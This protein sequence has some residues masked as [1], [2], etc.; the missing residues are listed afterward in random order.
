MV[1]GKILRPRF[2]L[3]A[4]MIIGLLLISACGSSATSTAQPTESINGTSPPNAVS[5]ARP[6]SAPTATAV[7]SA[8]QSVMMQAT[9]N[10]QGKYGG[11]IPVH[12][13]G[14]ISHW[15]MMEC[16]SGGTCMAPVSPFSN[17]LVQY[18]GETDDP[19]D[20]RGD[21]ATGWTLSEDGTSYVF[22]LPQ[23]ARWHDGVEITADDVVFSLEEMVRDDVPRSR[24]GQIGP[25]YKSSKALDPYTVQVDL[26]FATS[27]FLSILSLEFMKMWPKHWV[28]TDPATQKDMRLEEN[29]LGSGPFKMVEH[30]KDVSIKYEKN[31]DYFKEGLPYFDGMEYFM[32]NDSSRIVAAYKAQQVLMTSYLNSN[33]NVR[34]AQELAKSMEG[35]GEVFFAAPALWH[36]LLMNT[37]VEPFNNIKVRQAIQLVLHRQAFNE[38]FGA[39]QYQLGS[40]LPPDLWF[41]SST[42]DLLQ[43]PGLR[44]TADGEK[45]PRDIAEAQRLMAEAGYADGFKTTILGANFLGFPDMAQVA[46]DQMR[47]WLNIDAVVQPEEPAAGYV[48]YEAGDW[49]MGFHGSGIMVLDPDH[50]MAETYLATGARN[51]S[52]W[53]PSEITEMNDAQ[54]HE[55]DFDKRRD[56]VLQMEEYLLNVDSHLVITEWA[57]LIPYVDNRIKNYHVASGFA[58]HTM[59]EHLWYEP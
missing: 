55:P 36:A 39:G 18:N 6:T 31:E 7:P 57:A 58:S 47:R 2:L 48:R 23:D 54:Q 56:L 44:E 50:I 45:D 14:N 51:Y 9:A 10:P 38:I 13:A 26:K 8:Q 52:G 59:K 30:T 5:T 49:K 42:E 15:S 28:G 22:T 53:E 1:T 27:T 19:T 20:I 12:N 34:E 4:G 11:V 46:A 24:S 40:P 25:Y 41:S 21:L 43:L 16:G 35:K 37:E 33:M 3:I 29:I 17:G 32:I